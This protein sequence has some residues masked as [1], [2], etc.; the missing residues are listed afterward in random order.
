MLI[1]TLDNCGR[2]VYLVDPAGVFIKGT[3]K[4]FRLRILGQQRMKKFGFEF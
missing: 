3:S 2:L 4:Q 1:S